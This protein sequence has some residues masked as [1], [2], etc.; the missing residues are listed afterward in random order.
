MDRTP[1]RLGGFLALVVAFLALATTPVAAQ[2]VN[3]A[4]INN[5]NRKLLYVALPLMMSV[6]FIIFYTIYRY[7]NNDDPAPTEENRRLEIT[8]TVVTAIILAFVGIASMVVLANPYI[9]PVVAADN[10]PQGGGT[11]HYLQGAVQP[12]DPNAVEIEV[13]AYQWGW[14]FR[15]MDQENVTTKKKLVIPKGRDVYLHVSSKDVIHSFY[16]PK[17]G[18]KQDAMPGTYATIRT[19]ATEEGVYP[20]YCA[21]FCGSGHARMGGDVVVVSNEEYRTWVREQRN[22]G[23]ATASA[24]ADAKDGAASGNDTNLIGNATTE[25]GSD[26]D[27]LENA[28]NG[29]E[30]GTETPNP[31]LRAG[32]ATGAPSVGS[33]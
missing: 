11:N 9:S 19:K 22:G 2:S 6:E 31:R 4:L 20:F 33:A 1:A 32:D 25:T 12:D 18:L 21:E 24:V 29:T 3:K 17:L 10:S 23:N 5:L 27:L 13:L 7:R 8:W 15:Y 28:T 14:E 26:T 16:S 30:N